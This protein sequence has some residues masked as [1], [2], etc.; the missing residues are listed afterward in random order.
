MLLVLLRPGQGLGENPIETVVGIASVI[1]VGR[2]ATAGLGAGLKSAG[3]V[4]AATKLSDIARSPK[5]T[6]AARGVEVGDVVAGAEEWPLEVIGEGMMEGGALTL[7]HLARMRRADAEDVEEAPEIP[8]TPDTR[9]F[10]PQPAPE[11]PAP[12]TA[13]EPQTRQYELP[14]TDISITV[15][16]VPNSDGNIDNRHWQVYFQGTDVEESIGFTTE[17]DV[18]S[19]EGARDAAIQQLITASEA[20]EIPITPDTRTIVPP[21]QA[22]ARQNRE[23]KRAENRQARQ[24]KREGIE[25]DEDTPIR[26]MQL[27]HQSKKHRRSIYARNGRSKP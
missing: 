24:D 2:L 16:R 20:L 26:L 11:Q 12:E 14:N 7:S 4:A 17:D 10:T 5:F 19:Y 13:R 21:E 22:A 9:T 18:T 3:K 25:T 8:I 15:K 27:R 23:A 6:A 1:P